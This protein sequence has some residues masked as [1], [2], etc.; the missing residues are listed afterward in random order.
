MTATLV[1]DYLFGELAPMQRDVMTGHGAGVRRAAALLAALGDPQEQLR[2]IHVAGTAG[3]GSVCAFVA[4]IIETH[5][6]RVGRY[7]SPHAHTVLERFCL[8]GRP[9]PVGVLA[10]VIADVRAVERTLRAGPDGP[11]SMF[12]VATA[13]AFELFRRQRVDYAVIETGLGGLHDA[14]NVVRGAEKLSIITALGLDH[15][16]VLGSSIE[17]IAAQKAGILPSA[18]RALALS[19][20]IRSDLVIDTEAQRRGCVLDL[21]AP[22]EAARRIPS[23]LR[24]G[25]P[26]AHQRVNAGLAL[27]AA[28][29]LAARDGWR[30]EAGR[31]AAALAAAALPGRFERRAWN[32]HPLIL[33]GAHNPM[34]IAALVAA[35]AE[36]APDRRPVWVVGVK[37]DKDLGE[38]LRLVGPAAEQ[39]V[40]TEF[41]AADA[42]AAVP[43]AQVAAA[44]RAVGLARP[45]VE[46]DPGRALEV[47]VALSDGDTPVVVTGS[48][49][50][51]AAVGRR[52][53]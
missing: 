51:V 36:E 44:A 23:T 26:G 43:A 40:L 13:A 39:V 24:L 32:G 21:V 29:L 45:V 48:F 5:G 52:V 7:S 14:T 4:G 9:V 47:A 42:V 50:V 16:E 19:S 18:G 33:D 28:E 20:G 30:L 12:E 2:I 10:E 41:D 27:E 35:V 11:A 38:I 17:E 22:A 3:K 49:H 8:D 34:K 6:F 1:E 15:V 37:P 25:L 31:W 46:P 53:D